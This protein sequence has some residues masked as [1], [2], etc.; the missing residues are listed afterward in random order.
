MG[1]ILIIAA[2]TLVI[3]TEIAIVANLIYRV[4]H[5]SSSGLE[6]RAQFN[7]KRTIQERK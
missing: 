7:F 6:G 3:S 1:E 5:P 4:F 2:I